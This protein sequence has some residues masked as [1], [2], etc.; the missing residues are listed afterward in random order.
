MSFHVRVSASL[1]AADIWL[2][3]TAAAATP[4]NTL[5]NAYVL[6][7]VEDPAVTPRLMTIGLGLGAAVVRVSAVSGDVWVGL[8]NDYE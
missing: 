3:E 4:I 1:L 7:R 2:T 5:A 6:G 8:R